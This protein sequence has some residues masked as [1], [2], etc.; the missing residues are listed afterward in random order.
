MRR[1]RRGGEQSAAC[2]MDSK[3]SIDER[4]MTSTED[5]VVTQLLTMILSQQKMLECLKGMVD[6]HV[7]E[8]CALQ[9]QQREFKEK[10]DALPGWIYGQPQELL[11]GHS[12]Y[13]VLEG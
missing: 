7:T 10:L 6:M 8:L 9:K 1:E 11:T 5:L 12:V 2:G 3:P 4:E 13:K